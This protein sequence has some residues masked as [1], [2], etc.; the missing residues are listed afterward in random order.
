MLPLMRAMAVA[1]PP[2]WRSEPCSVWELPAPMIDR[3]TTRQA[4]T[5]LGAAATLVRDTATGSAEAAGSIALVSESA[6]AASIAAGGGE[7]A[8]DLSVLNRVLE[9]SWLARAKP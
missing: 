6:A 4:L 2:G 8:T 9:S 1:L 3:A 5:T 7:F